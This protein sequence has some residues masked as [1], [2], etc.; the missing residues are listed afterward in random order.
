MPEGTRP[1]PRVLVAAV[2]QGKSRTIEELSRITIEEVKAASY[3]FVRSVTVK[4][5]RDFIQALVTNVSNDNEAD[6]I[7]MVGGTGFGPYDEVCEALDPFFERRIEGFGE[8]YRR[9]LRDEAGLGA[10]SWLF[11][12]TAGVYNRCLV[13]A[14]TGSPA[15][16]KRALGA[17]VMPN[18][19]DGVALATGGKRPY[20]LRG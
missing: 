11:R 3:H 10:R 16:V 15:D 18:I 5:E 9:L 20:D 8:A 6:A 2:S 19:A 14:L 7:V 17:L 12:A 13:V 1:V 4:G